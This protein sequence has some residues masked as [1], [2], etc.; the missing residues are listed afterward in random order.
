MKTLLACLI[1]AFALAT[2]RGAVTWSM[3]SETEFNNV[4]T[5]SK[6]F[7]AR[8]IE[9][10]DAPNPSFYELG[11][12]DGDLNPPDQ[13]AHFNWVVNTSH[14]FRIELDAAGNCMFSLDGIV[15]LTDQP[16]G[17]ISELWIGN[18]NTTSLSIQ[19]IWLRDLSFNSTSLTN[20]DTQGPVNFAG[21]RISGIESDEWVLT[22]KINWHSE[23]DTLAHY[24]SVDIF[25]SVMTVP[26][27]SS[28]LLVLIGGSMLLLK[29]SRR[30]SAGL[31]LLVGI[32]APRCSTETIGKRRSHHACLRSLFKMPHEGIGIT[33][34][35]LASVEYPV[36]ISGGSCDYRAG[37]FWHRSAVIGSN[38]RIY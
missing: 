20:L 2:A 35:C 24:S 38:R 25:G 9:Q 16:L 3:I 29:R 13:T 18:R 6:L 15:R 19:Q 14:T 21:L 26:E 36:K 23:F 10:G 5:S 12:S 17:A 11:I 34:A 27:P 7:G 33:A 28:S 1:A 8:M 31:F 37:I 22:G 32:S 4:N 30:T